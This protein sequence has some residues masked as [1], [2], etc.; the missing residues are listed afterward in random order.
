[1]RRFIG[2]II[3]VAAIFGS[4]SVWAQSAYDDAKWA[5]WMDGKGKTLPAGLPTGAGTIRALSPGNSLLYI[6]RARDLSALDGVV[7]A[8]QA[9]ANKQTYGGNTVESFLKA[10]VKAYRKLEGKKA[11]VPVVALSFQP[12]LYPNRTESEDLLNITFGGFSEY[13]A[14]AN[15]RNSANEGLSGVSSMLSREASQHEIYQKLV[16]T[17]AETLKLYD[18]KE[19]QKLLIALEKSARQEANEGNRERMRENRKSRTREDEKERA[20]MRYADVNLAATWSLM[21]AILTQTEAEVVS[22]RLPLELKTSLLEYAKKQ[23]KSGKVIDRFMSMSCRGTSGISVQLGCSLQERFLGCNI[24]TEATDAQL[25]K[26]AKKIL[27]QAEDSDEEQQLAALQMVAGMR[28]AIPKDQLEPWL[29]NDN[30]EINRLA[31][32]LTSKI[33]SVNVLAERYS[34][35]RRMAE[36]EK[37]RLILAQEKADNLTPEERREAKKQRN[38]EKNAKR[39]ALHKNDKLSA[40]ERAEAEVERAKAMQR[41][42]EKK[43]QKAQEKLERAKAREAGVRYEGEDE[44]A[45]E[46][47]LEDIELQRALKR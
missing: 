37:E 47:A 43:L 16:K 41:V 15:Y 36:D 26:L 19:R 27:S 1:M 44:D 39:R 38:A 2:T 8:D 7:F 18:G 35:K 17:H 25:S 31:N 32:R 13:G 40:T 28:I 42:N 12:G 10:T 6:D 46:S 9:K 11:V 20:L 5:S 34:C 30:P 33:S 3:F 22:I 23:K 29:E 45:F 24:P 14:N 21:E 4:T